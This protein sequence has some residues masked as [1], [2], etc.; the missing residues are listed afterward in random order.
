MNNITQKTAGG[1]VYKNGHVLLIKKNKKW[2]LPKGKI[3]KHST[4]RE[5]AIQEIHEE[6]GVEKNNLAISCKLAPTKY[7]KK[8]NGEVII[9]HTTWYAV[10]F[11]GNLDD[12]LVPDYHEGITKCQWVSFE[13]INSKMKKSFPHIIYIINYYLSL[14]KKDLIR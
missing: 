9:K 12:V 2:D 14:I 6:T 4:K 11:L 7:I 13:K 1:V 8:I 10:R 3:E 5:T